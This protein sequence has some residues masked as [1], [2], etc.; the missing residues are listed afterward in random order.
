MDLE[1]KRE[2]EAA[3]L[4]NISAN[5]DA[6]EAL[7]TGYVGDYE[8][9][10]YRFYHQS[11]KVYYLQQSTEKIVG[12]LQSLAPHLALNA[13]FMQIV[14]EGTGKEFTRSDNARWIEVTRPVVEAFFHAR[15]FLEMACRYGR[16]LATPPEVLPSGWAAILYLFN[17]R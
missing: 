10:V 17:L 13:W 14:R 16:E 3:L 11:F 4:R 8:D 2:E 9:P 12:T 15:Y 5:I 6:L 1:T 7:L